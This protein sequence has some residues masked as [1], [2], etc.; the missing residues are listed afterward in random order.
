MKS[1]SEPPQAIGNWVFHFPMANKSRV[2]YKTAQRAEKAL[3]IEFKS[4]EQV[5]W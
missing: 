2:F 5:V 1:C 4:N 3:A